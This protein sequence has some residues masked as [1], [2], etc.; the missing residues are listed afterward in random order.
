MCGAETGGATD[1]GSS[2]GNE[3]TN[4]VIAHC[5]PSLCLLSI[6]VQ[7]QTQWCRI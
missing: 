5:R 1:G 4:I 7:I 2:R 3:T 6:R